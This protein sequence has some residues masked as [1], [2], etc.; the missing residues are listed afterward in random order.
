MKAKAA[1]MRAAHE[2]LTIEEIEVDK[3]ARR[4]VL[5]RTAFAGVCHSDLH[6]IEGLYPIPCPCVLG[7]E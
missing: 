2:P 5:I 1:V 6:F 4:E 7:H 3:P